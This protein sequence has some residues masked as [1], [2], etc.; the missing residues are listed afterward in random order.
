MRHVSLH[1]PPSPQ[2]YW[3]P[4]VYVGGRD[5]QQNKSP[6]GGLGD[7]ALGAVERGWR[8]SLW[9]VRRQPGGHRGQSPGT[10]DAVE[11]QRGQREFQ[12]RLQRRLPA[13]GRQCLAGTNRWESHWGG[14][15]GQKRRAGLTVTPKWGGVP[16][17][18]S[19]ASL[20]G[21]PGRQGGVPAG[22]C[23]PRDEQHYW[24]AQQRTVGR[25]AWQRAGRTGRYWRNKGQGPM[26]HEIWSSS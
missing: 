22:T 11:G 2:K 12:E 23:R 10:S 5:G 26:M 16:P 13:A 17:P 25:K 9:I 20:P 8:I 15:G 19:S 1:A 3:Q 18:T 6:F 7:Q 21:S 14:G 4:T 24:A